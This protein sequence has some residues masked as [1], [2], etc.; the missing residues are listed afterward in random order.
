LNDTFA[1]YHQ[2]LQKIIITALLVLY[3]SSVLKYKNYL[4]HH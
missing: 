3:T 1:S 4:N 2:A